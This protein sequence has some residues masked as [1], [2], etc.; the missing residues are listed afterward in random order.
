MYLWFPLA[1][2]LVQ[3]AVL[4]FFPAVRAPAAYLY[5]VLAPL[6]AAIAL[7]WRAYIVSRAARTGWALLASALVI[8]SVGAFC[9]LWQELV[10]G[11][12]NEMYRDSMLGF[13][14]ATVP[15]LFLLATDWRPRGRYLLAATDALMS[16]AVGYIYFL[17]TWSMI[18]AQSAP[19]ESGTTYLIWQFDAQN[20]YILF[21]ALLRWYVAQRNPERDLFR[22]L[23]VYWALY[24]VI[25]T[26]NDHFI[27]GDPSFGPEYGSIVSLAFAVL[28]GFALYRPSLRPIRQANQALVR[29]VRGGS[30]IMLAGALL[31][32]SLAL[33]R[34]DYAWGVAGVVISVLGI[35]LRSTLSQVGFIE[36]EGSFRKERS[37]LQ[38]IAWTDGLTGIPNRHFLNEALARAD[39]TERRSHKPL[40]V[41]MIDIDHFKRLNDRYGHPAGDACLR[42]VARVLREALARQDDVVARYGGEEFIVLLRDTD[43]DGAQAV[44][45]RLREVVEALGIE[46][47]ESPIGVVTVS[48][49]V[50][51]ALLHGASSATA[52]CELADKALYEA[53]IG[54]RNQV[55]S[56][57]TATA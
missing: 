51:S 25:V 49:G 7:G 34:V 40:A 50:A 26:V 24:T 8:W 31:L 38:S 56:L 15:I 41:L 1:F 43:L 44:G 11:H 42:E 12:Q 22:A 23:A 4:V 21:G 36:R 37:T 20:L 5:M 6:A 3:V 57:S 33:I 54:G 16:A 32:L 46:N 18:T 9:N 10:L 47:Q 13:A 35:G 2:L 45:E 30:P 27:A 29:T 19:S 28:A 48:V 53:K 39:R 17:L 55:R 52:L 14:I